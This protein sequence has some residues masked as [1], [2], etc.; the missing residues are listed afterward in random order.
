[1]E[2]RIPL[3]DRRLHSF[4]TQL[5]QCG[6]LGVRHLDVRQ[7]AEHLKQFAIRG[8]QIRKHERTLR[9]VDRFNHA[10][11]YRDANAID[12]LGL[13]EVDHDAPHAAGEKLLA[14]VLY[15]LSSELIEVRAGINHRRILEE[16]GSDLST[17][18]VPP[19]RQPDT[20]AE[21]LLG[22]RLTAIRDVSCY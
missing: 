4:S 5:K 6:L 16:P 2:N 7:Q 19:Y 10:Q 22:F 17:H 11:Q 8:I 21:G 3:L 13:L 9:A 20:S 12:Q 14:L 15:T 18:S 1:M